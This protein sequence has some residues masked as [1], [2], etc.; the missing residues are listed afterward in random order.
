MGKKGKGSK[1]NDEKKKKKEK[2]KRRYSHL[3]RVFRDGT[4]STHGCSDE[5]IHGAVYGF[6]A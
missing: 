1:K 4:R 2:E 6:W 3:N 5:K